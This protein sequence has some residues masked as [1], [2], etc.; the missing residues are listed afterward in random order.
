MVDPPRIERFCSN[1]VQSLNTWRRKYNKSSRSRGQ[2]STSQRDVTRAKIAKLWI[3]Q[4]WLFDFAEIY[5]R[6][7]PRDIRSTTSFQGQRVKGQGHSVTW[8]IRMKKI[9]TFH[10]RIAWL[11]LNFVQ[12]I[13]QHSAARD[14]CSRYKVKYSN[15]NNFTADCPISLTFRT[16]FDRGEAGLLYMF[17]V[18]GQRSR[19]QRNVTYKQ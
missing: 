18:K 3:T 8:R 9:V 5:Y 15:C 1:F 4:L 17:K 11:S 12:I 7:W 16:E 6:L 13:P 19:S 2:R 14:T 10:E